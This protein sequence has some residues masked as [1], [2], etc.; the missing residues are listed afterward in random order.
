MT[1]DKP[2]A[3][4][5]DWDGTLINSLNF[6]FKAHNYARAQ[7]GMPAFTMQDFEGYFGKP[8]DVL[9]QEIYGVHKDTA[10]A[11]FDVFVRENHLE[12]LSPVDNAESLLKTI[13]DFGIVCGVV[14][15]KKSDFVRSEIRHL[16]WDG[17]M[18]AIIGSGDA[19]EDKPSAAPLM[20]ALEQSNLSEVA[21][22][23]V[24]YVGDT[25]TDQGCAKAAGCKFVFIDH[26]AHAPDWLGV[27]PPILVS[28]NCNQIRDYLLQIGGKS[29]KQ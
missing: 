27:Y 15:N 22:T 9:Y 8:R 23:N 13:C 12:E 7:L 11:H 18:S 6:I 1:K 4:F 2:A 16:G 10:R 17:Y 20:L 5:F 24:W 26:L 21:L 28:K 19:P 25:D 14:S 3:I 29:L